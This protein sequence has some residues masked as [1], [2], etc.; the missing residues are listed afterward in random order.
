MNALKA[1]DFPDFV[2]FVSSLRCENP[3]RSSADEKFASYAKTQLTEQMIRSSL[4]SRWRYSPDQKKKK[5][6]TEQWKKK[7]KKRLER[8]RARNAWMQRVVCVLEQVNGL[9]SRITI[10]IV[11]MET[12]SLAAVTHTHTHTHN[13]TKWKPY[14]P[15]ISPLPFLFPFFP[16]EIHISLSSPTDP[17]ISLQSQSPSTPS[18]TP[19]IMSFNFFLFH[20]HFFSSALWQNA[21]QTCCKTAGEIWQMRF[22]Y[23]NFRN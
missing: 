17:L 23:C 8:T 18:H 7:K 20:Q 1:S 22:S 4:P 19:H 5:K 16:H 13:S 12:R 11:C 21:K 15:L 6:K 2:A 10:T 3:K 14:T 9:Y